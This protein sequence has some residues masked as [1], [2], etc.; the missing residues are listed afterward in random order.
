[1]SQGYLNTFIK[2]KVLRMKNIQKLSIVMLLACIGQVA[3]PDENKADSLVYFDEISRARGLAFGCTV[4]RTNQEIKALENKR[5]SFV[6]DIHERCTKEA[7][8]KAN[9]E[10]A[11]LKCVTRLKTVNKR[12]T[13]MDDQIK[14]M[15]AAKEKAYGPEI[16]ALNREVRARWAVLNGQY[17]GEF[18]EFVKKFENGDS[19]VSESVDCLNNTKDNINAM[20]LI[21]K[22]N[23]LHELHSGHAKTLVEN[24]W[25]A[26][27]KDKEI[28]S[29][30]GLEPLKSSLKSLPYPDRGW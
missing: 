4:P 25:Y 3:K 7:I 15:L 20:D 14:A 24:M 30:V 27:E 23:Q 2:I 1:M 12:S 17:F 11:Y 5:P 18:Q 26:L 8:E 29:M 13:D 28:I 22:W 16:D 21:A 10:K 19:R 9:D 6:F